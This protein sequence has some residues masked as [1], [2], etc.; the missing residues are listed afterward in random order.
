MGWKW[1]SVTLGAIA[2][3]LLAWLTIA[4]AEPH[5]SPTCDEYKHVTRGMAALRAP[6]TRLNYPHPPL[7]QALAMLPVALTTN[8]RFEERAGWSRGALARATSTY[9]APDYEKGRGYL[10]QGRLMNAAWSSALLIFLV[11]WLRRQFDDI[12]ALAAGALYATC[13]IVL[14]HAGLVTNDFAVAAFTILSLAAVLAYLEHGT[15]WRLLLAALSVAALPIAKVSGLVVVMILLPL[16]IWY[17]VR[18]RGVYADGS[19]ARAAL[20]L[21]RDYAF[22]AFMVLLA[23]NAIYRFHHSFLTPR[24]LASVDYANPGAV[25]DHDYAVPFL[26]HWPSSWRVPLP[27][28]FLRSVEAIRVKSEKG[29]AGPWFGTRSSAG[30]M[31]YFPFML[32]GKPQALLLP[33]LL[34]GFALGPRKMLRGPG[35]WLLLMALGFLA[36]AMRSSINIGVRHVLP[37]VMCLLVLGGRATSVIV[38]FAERHIRRWRPVVA[39]LG[40]L[41]GVSL[42]AGVALA[43]PAFV[44]DFNV[45]V[46]NDWGRQAGAVAEDWGQD[47][48]ALAAALKQRSI[49]KI[50]YVP[51]HSFSRAELQRHGIAVRGLSCRGKLGKTA[52][53]IHLAQWQRSRSC[54]R[55]LRKLEP[56]LVINSN[57]LVFLP[58]SSKADARAKPRLRRHKKERARHTPVSPEPSAGG[59]KAEDGGDATDDSDKDD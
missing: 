22:I 14:A 43:F 34:V 56:D 17:L 27:R 49:R 42:L 10:R 16:P 46:G 30:N 59:A 47:G 28:N 4:L 6:D 18:R 8:P 51:R 37:T 21:L 48:A 9:I 12:T 23:A 45:L 5:N 57:V 36:I 52:I 11:A 50:A 15:I 53:A 40:A 13:P 58:V 54:Y 39:G 29:H 7:A 19:R 1:D 55:A 35:K 32:L 20:R 26:E 24:E 33:L 44:G 38:E 41:A 3:A 31:L 25:A 2:L